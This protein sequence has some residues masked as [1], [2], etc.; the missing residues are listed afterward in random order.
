MAPIIEVRGVSKRFGWVISEPA[1]LFL[2]EAAGG[3]GRDVFGWTTTVGDMQVR[4]LQ[5]R[6]FVIELTI[7][8]VLRH[9][10]RGLIPETAVRH[11]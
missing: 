7:T 1:A 4:A 5:M 8:L 2:F 11:D 3:W 9:A 6:V 10:P